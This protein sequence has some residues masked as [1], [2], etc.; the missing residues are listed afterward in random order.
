MDE[1]KLQGYSMANTGFQF[2]SIKYASPL[3]G[4][5]DKDFTKATVQLALTEEMFEPI[6]QRTIDRIESRIKAIMEAYCRRPVYVKILV[7]TKTDAS[8]TIKADGYY[9][10]VLE[11]SL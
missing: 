10:H 1:S 7:V 4:S 2:T 8:C 11:I 3:L 9:D 5:F 6:V